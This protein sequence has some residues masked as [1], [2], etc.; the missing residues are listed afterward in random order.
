MFVGQARGAGRAGEGSDLKMS[1][2]AAATV[3]EEKKSGGIKG[4]LNTFAKSIIQPLTYMSVV[5]VF[6]VIGVILTNDTI[7]EALPFLSWTPIAILGDIIYESLMFIV[8]NLSVVF[9]VGI[10]A[11]MAKDNKGHAALIAL[12]SYFV[13]LEANYYT[14]VGTETLETASELTGLYGTGQTEIFGIQVVD[15]GVFSGI[16]LGCICGWAFNKFSHKQFGVALEMFSGTRFAFLVMILISWG[17]GI[18]F[19]YVW[20]P[21]EWLISSLATFISES[22]N[23]GLFIYGVL[24]KLLVPTGLH[25][26]VYMPLEYTA[27]GGTMTID[28]V[29]YVGAYAIHMAEMRAG[30]EFADSVYYTSFAFN[31]LWPY[32]GIGLAFI[33]TAYPENKV[34]TRNEMIPLMIS[35]VLS[36]ITE[37]MD[38]LFVFSAPILFVVHSLLSGVFL[39]LLKVLSIPASTAGGLIN[40]IVSNLVIGVERSNWP[41]MVVLGVIDVVVYYFV[42]T[43]LIR[44]LDLHTPG[45]EPTEELIE[46]GVLVAAEGVNVGSAEAAVAAGEAEVA[47]AV[48]VAE[49]TDASSAAPEGVDAE[50]VDLIAGLGGKENIVS[51]ENCFTRLRI[52]VRDESLINEELINHYKNSGI[53]RSGTDIQI[54]I[55]LQVAEAHSKLEQALSKM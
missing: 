28:G 46:E 13:F 8:N 17:L 30:M 53:T 37:P 6:L 35:A 54:I 50:I 16:L 51:I 38:F 27:L 47:A 14:L 33:S 41:M 32:I 9:C 3:T 45:R 23:L 7:A 11:A 20:E 31:N 24:N 55:G 44:K 42:F 49:S 40:V 26:L 18:A 34:A 15:T 2:A 36:A 19:V 52:E 12:M 48:A 1:E 10:A 39:V 25:H 43:F 29:T 21:I 4:A 5:G 22:G